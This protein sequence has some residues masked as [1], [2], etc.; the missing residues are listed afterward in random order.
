M[1]EVAVGDARAV[2]KV[3]QHAPEAVGVQILSGRSVEILHSKN[4]E[5]LRKDAQRPSKR[6][7]YARS[8]QTVKV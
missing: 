7:L 6:L 3:D 1:H 2:Q 4:L 5:S 8:P